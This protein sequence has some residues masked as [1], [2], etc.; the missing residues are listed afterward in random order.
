MRF[1]C[2]TLCLSLAAC[3]FIEVESLDDVDDNPCWT[4]SNGDT[5]SDPVPF[6]PYGVVPLFATDDLDD[7]EDGS[8][9][10]VND[11]AT[12]AKACAT[13][14]VGQTGHYRLF[15]SNFAGSCSDQLDE[16]AYFTVRNTCNP[17]GWPAE[18]NA[19]DYFV[20]EDPDNTAAC[21]GDGDCPPGASC[22][23]GSVRCCVADR[24]FLGTFLLIEDEPNELCLEHWCPRY[25]EQL[26]AGMDWGFT[27]D[28]CTDINSLNMSVTG[29]AGCLDPFTR[30]RCSWGCDAG[31]CLPDPCDAM[32]CA[33]YCMD[34][35]CLDENPCG[36]LSCIHGCVRGRCLQ[37][38]GARGPDADRDGFGDLA[39]CD[40]HAPLAS[41]AHA[42]RCGNATDD[43]CDGRV[44]EG[45][46]GA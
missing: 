28:R 8:I 2:A 13:L 18:R 20:I 41:P 9:H 10:V 46:C 38:P 43:D 25:S 27:L 14:R 34:G 26:A 19:A 12:E 40:D 3:G 4:R 24:L 42:E 45:D 16:T 44:D 31:T 33:A 22:S 11:G 37:G 7:E 35:V 29:F 39:D 23:R 21:A 32:T 30:H 1:G 17:D 15:G 6:C 36:R 5:C